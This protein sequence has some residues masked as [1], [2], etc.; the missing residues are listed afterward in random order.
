MQRRGSEYKRAVERSDA[1][2]R[3]GQRVR[4]GA[5]APCQMLIKM[6][7]R[8]AET[9]RCRRVYGARRGAARIARKIRLCSGSSAAMRVCSAVLCAAWREA[10]QQDASAA[11]R[12][13]YMNPRRDAAMTQT[14]I[15]K[16]ARRCR[17]RE[18]PVSTRGCR[19]QYHAARRW[20]SSAGCSAASHVAV[21]QHV[22]KERASSRAAALLSERRC[23]DD[24][25][26][27]KIV[28]H[29]M[30]SPRDLPDATPIS[31]SALMLPGVAACAPATPTPATGAT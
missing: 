29:A 19:A 2:A 27:A 14:T 17:E 15:T 26:T 6:R 25:H 16:D 8:C 18:T 11:Q 10:C 22:C 23:Q 5:N 1:H 3:C 21:C 31:D 7:M 13:R 12:A 30:L 9:Y 4:Y 20:R 24:E 28:H